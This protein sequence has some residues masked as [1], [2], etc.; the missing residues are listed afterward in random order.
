MNSPALSRSSTSAN[1]LIDGRGF[2]PV[3]S[4]NASLLAARCSCAR[5]PRLLKDPLAS[6]D[7]GH[8][9]EIL[10]HLIRLRDD[11]NVPMVYVSHTA[12][13]LRQI[14]TKVV[15]L[16]AGRVTAVGDLDL[17]KSADAHWPE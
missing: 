15:R 7:A 11:S 2:Y 12:A 5:R 16:E 6:L 10:P 9:R 13:E 3:A 4:A 8:K 14:A 1:C 17:L